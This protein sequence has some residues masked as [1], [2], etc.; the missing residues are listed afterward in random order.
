MERRQTLSP[1]Q[2]NRNQ[3]KYGNMNKIEHLGNSG[4]T[5]NWRLPNALFENY[6]SATL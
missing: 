2:V 1:T 6:W 5:W 3:H 4:L